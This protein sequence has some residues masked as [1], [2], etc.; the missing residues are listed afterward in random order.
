MAVI[1]A[2]LAVLNLP[3]TT[4]PPGW[5]ARGQL[6]ASFRD[7]TTALHA[8]DF[9]IDPGEDSTLWLLDTP[10]GRAQLG[11]H[12]GG[13]HFLR[14][15]DTPV[16]WTI[17][18]PSADVLPWIHKLVTH[19]T[20]GFP[21]GGL[22]LPGADP[23]ALIRAYQRYLDLRAADLQQRLEHV[24]EPAHPATVSRWQLLLS[25]SQCLRGVLHL[26]GTPHAVAEALQQAANRLSGAA[27]QDAPELRDEFAATVRVL[28]TA[29]LAQSEAA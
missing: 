18:A 22:A 14:S 24:S 8:P 2:N 3:P 28:A 7:L 12:L 21:H 25:A 1:R 5:A 23:I 26:A 15:P 16:T 13:A 27:G 11:H 20:A 19:S 17:Q 29:G 9:G 4:S 10:G 6:H